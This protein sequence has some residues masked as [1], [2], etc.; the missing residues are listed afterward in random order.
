MTSA[1]NPAARGTDGAPEPKRVH[2]Y[3]VYTLSLP[4]RAIRSTTGLLA[5][6]VRESAGLLLPQSFRSSKSYSVLVQQMLDYLAEGVGGVQKR[7]SPGE[8]QQEV[9]GYVARKT[10]GN[11]VELAGLA[12][13]HVSPLT[14]LAVVS[15]VAY[16]SQAYLKELAEEL[17]KQ[18]IIEPDSTISHAQDLLDA[19]GKA[20]GVTASA[21]DT[22]PL[23]VEGL[24]KVIDD[25][26]QAVATIDPTKVL[27][28][29]ELVRLW[30]QMH[31]VANHEGVSVWEVSS[32][33][34]F[35]SLNKLTTLGRGALSGVTVAGR[36]FDRHVIDHYRAGLDTIGKKGIYATLAETSGP[37]IEA[38]WRNFS[39]ESP[40]ITQDV[41][42]GRLIG[43][44][45]SAARGWL[46]KRPPETSP[47]P[48]ADANSRTAETDRGGEPT[49]A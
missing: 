2:D 26:R 13:M 19:V 4:E 17:K 23:S 10:V 24:K 20:S 14:L 40:T 29:A 1:E 6:T 35:F 47:P 38:V 5:G 48:G 12:T 46:G 22:P 33:M 18:G 3:L 45:W 34:T 44:A 30:N 27:P 21:L 28:Q 16:G 41:V 32:A 25:T 9:E 11:F 36:L 37:Y 43:K 42:T 8:E 15:D 39:A 49:V 31:E 7:S